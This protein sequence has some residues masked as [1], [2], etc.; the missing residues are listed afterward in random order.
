[1][2]A[3]DDWLLRFT[4]AAAQLDP[5]QMVAGTVG[6]G[7]NRASDDSGFLFGVNIKKS[8]S[9]SFDSCICVLGKR[10]FVPSIDPLGF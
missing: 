1:M 5:S 2:S 7:R 3:R 8:A 10:R 6:S 4:A 9:Y